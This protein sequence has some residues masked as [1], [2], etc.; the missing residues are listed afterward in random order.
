MKKIKDLMKEYIEIN[1][2]PIKSKQKLVKVTK[3][4]LLVP[5][6]KWDLV[7][8]KTLEKKFY[9]KSIEKRNNFIEK[10]FEYENKKN[11][12]AIILISEDVV[13]IILSTKKLHMVTEL[14][15]EYASYADS[16]FSDLMTEW[17]KNEKFKFIPC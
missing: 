7:N 13:K 11:H 3:K 9:F 15:K 2:E 8:N 6:N 14:D 10:L 17:K 5:Q 1:Y 16:V 4:V 12:H